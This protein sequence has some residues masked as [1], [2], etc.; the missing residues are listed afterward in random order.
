VLTTSKGLTL[1]DRAGESGGTIT[2]TGS[3]AVAWPP[4]L[5]VG[6]KLPALPAGVSG[7]VAKVTRPGGAVQVTYNGMP[8]YLWQGDTAPGQASGQGVGGFEAVTVS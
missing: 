1:Y 6:G 3:C 8:L 4:L 7:T 2:C 5:V